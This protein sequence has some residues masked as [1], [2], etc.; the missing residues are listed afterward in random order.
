MDKIY[1]LLKFSSS[2]IKKTLSRRG[3]HHAD[4]KSN[5]RR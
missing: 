2:V 5:N 4:K 1:N 3:Y